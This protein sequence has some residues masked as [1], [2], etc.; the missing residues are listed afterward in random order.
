MKLRHLLRGV[1]VLDTKADL[2]I[3][4]RF[5]TCDSRQVQP[6]CLFAAISGFSDDGNR[7]VADAVQKG[8]AAVV[9]A[10][11]P[12]EDV[13]YIL[14]ENDRLALALIAEN[15][16]EHPATSMKL[17]GV[18]GTNGK[19]S[20]TMLLKQV[21]E[22]AAGAKVGL[23]GTVQNMIGD[24]L[25]PAK[26][27]TPD[28]LEL[29][30][31]LAQMRDAGCTYAVMEVS[32]HALALHRTAGLCFDV[33]AFTNLTEDHL[34]FHRT[35]EAYCEAKA[36]LF[37][38]CRQAVLNGDDPW[39]DKIR[40]EAACPCLTISLE[41]RGDLCVEKICL[42]PDGVTYTANRS[43]ISVPVSVPIP[44]RFTVY[45][46][47]TV[48]GIALQLGL[49]LEL[50]AAALAQA[51]G[52]RGRAE[53]IPT[54]GKPYTVLAD[55]AH[56]PDGLE[57]I[58]L[59]ARQFCAGRLILVFGCGGNRERGKRPIMGRIGTELSD[60]AVITSDN[61]RFEDPMDIISDILSGI[62]DDRGNYKIIENRQKAI[63]YA[64]DIAEKDDIII[65]AG[66]GCQEIRGISYH[67]DERE[68]VSAYLRE[69]EE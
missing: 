28:S 17:V 15:F 67:L 23:I 8:A 41:Q 54:P 48:L 57:N 20:V 14:V 6:G 45:N 21:L 56:T 44:G 13:P 5:V 47:L 46:S 11:V 39:F 30:R 36:A 24:D 38:Q 26:R 69:T 37:R 1:P 9:T 53:V 65:L 62:P 61:P 2:D 33:A 25:L 58:L 42:L 68:E 63:R 64:M 50:A 52:I 3:P 40:A 55:Y 35:M 22:R 18:T 34:D 43:G 29:Q 66:K 4:V 51:K 12:S 27:T 31:L 7:Y 19:T 16:Y 10:A 60:F 49:E 59:T 32:S